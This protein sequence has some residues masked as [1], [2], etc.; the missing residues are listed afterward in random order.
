MGTAGWRGHCL[1][2]GL[3]RLL[4]SRA[5]FLHCVRLCLSL[6]GKEGS[7]TRPWRSYP[8]HILGRDEVTRGEGRWCKNVYYPHTLPFTR[9]VPI[10]AYALLGCCVE[11]RQR[12]GAASSCRGG[13]LRF[14]S[15]SSVLY[16]PAPRTALQE[17]STAWCYWSRA[18]ESRE[19]FQSN[20]FPRRSTGSYQFL[21]HGALRFQGLHVFACT[22]RVFS[23]VVLITEW[24]LCVPVTGAAYLQVM[25]G[26]V[27]VFKYGP[28]SS[29]LLERKQQFWAFHIILRL[30]KWPKIIENRAKS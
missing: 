19:T 2:R 5:S 9:A 13:W 7:Q 12:R 14:R 27:R 21:G 22:L 28:V 29:T 16:I 20:T 17:K 24:E 18:K 1:S 15:L 6:P 26:L 4:G 30:A 3:S 23:H 8:W 11:G 10:P 25:S